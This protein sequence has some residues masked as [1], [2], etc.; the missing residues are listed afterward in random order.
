MSGT[1]SDPFAP[2]PF[3]A[4][5]GDPSYS[6]QS[7]TLG[8]FVFNGWEVPEKVSWGGQQRMT[9]HKFVGGTRY[10]DVMGDDNQD[11]S[12]S[13][14]FLSPDAA[15]R[16]D[17]LDQLR[18]A[19]AAIELVFA[20]R[21]YIVVIAN[22]V[23][24]QEMQYNVPYSITLTPLSD[25]SFVPP[26][27][28]SP[29]AA[30]TFDINA[31]AAIAVAPPLIA[32]QIAVA[33]IPPL[34]FPMTAIAAGAAATVALASAVTAADATIAT[35]QTL[36]D[37]Q[38]AAVAAAEVAAANLA[39]ATTVVGA[40]AGMQAALAATYAS[41]SAAA[42]AGYVGRASTNIANSQ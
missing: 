17:Q 15:F 13:G 5:F 2:S 11:I 18:K 25:N 27:V 26:P 41:A 7:V 35:A 33:A 14:R 19:G 24:N 21:Y 8:D 3:D 28:I 9:V 38:I 32:A 22:F 40:V 34:L 1:F 30:V 16:A 10:I 23:A 20:G 4:S 39:G 42:I 36:A 12:W 37:N 29:L 31:V 6:D